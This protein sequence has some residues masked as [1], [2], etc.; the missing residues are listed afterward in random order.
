MICDYCTAEFEIP[1]KGSGGKNRL[2]CFSCL[3][4][5]LSRQERN[6]VRN[7]LYAK[8]MREHKESIGCLGCGYN[9]YGGALEW[10]HPEDDKDDNVADVVKKSWS[11]YLGEVSKC[12]LL[13]SCCHKEV[14]AGIRRV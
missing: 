11:A 10:H 1:K 9:A 4:S 12:V 2:F 3:P 6:K 8:R 14:H 13:C 7:D 5:D